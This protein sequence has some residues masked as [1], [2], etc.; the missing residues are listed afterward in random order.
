MAKP[1]RQP[2]KRAS[3]AKKAA[4]PRSRDN[5]PTQA[6][7]W[8]AQRQA[9]R[10]RLVLTRAAVIGGLVAVVVGVGAWQ[11]NTRRQARAVIASFAG[12]S[13]E[14]D[15]RTDPGRVNEHTASPVFTLN[16]PSG[17]VH[18]PSPARPGT[19]TAQSA[20]TD[21]QV[22]HALEHGLIAIWYQPSLAADDVRRLEEIADDRRE[23]VLLLPREGLPQKV[24]ATAWHRRLLCSDVEPEALERFADAYEG[25]GPENV[26]T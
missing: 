21:G 16:P 22:V 15:T 13:C 1:K 20:P 23:A 19:F 11:V 14:Y 2:Q 8:E 26:A 24:A 17:G 3:V 10:R 4:K 9:R 7:R 18:E 25:K 5:R 12:A 6:E